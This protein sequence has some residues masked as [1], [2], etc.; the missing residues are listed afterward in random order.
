MD[1]MSIK[2]RLKRLEQEITPKKA[3]YEFTIKTQDGKEILISTNNP[4]ADIVRAHERMVRE[5]LIK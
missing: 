3:K 2:K 5:D 1:N 4:A